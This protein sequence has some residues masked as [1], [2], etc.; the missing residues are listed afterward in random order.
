MGYK[1][2][3][4]IMG[5]LEVGGGALE[6]LRYMGMPVPNES[7]ER[8]EDPT[9]VIV[10][11]SIVHKEEIEV[12]DLSSH[13]I[14][15]LKIDETRPVDALKVSETRAA[16]PIQIG[17]GARIVKAFFRVISRFI[18]CRVRKTHARRLSVRQMSYKQ[19]KAGSQ[20]PEIPEP[21]SIED[22]NNRVCHK[23]M[24]DGRNVDEMRKAVDFMLVNILAYQLPGKD[25]H[26][27]IIK[28]P[29]VHRDLMVEYEVKRTFVHANGLVAYALEPL[30]DK[31]ALPRLLFRGTQISMFVKAGDDNPI[32]GIEEDMEKKIGFRSYDAHKGEISYWLEGLSKKAIVLGHSLGGAFALRTTLDLKNQSKIE[33]CFVYNSP[34]IE[35]ETVEKQPYPPPI[36]FCAIDGDPVSMVGSIPKDCFVY[37]YESKTK[38]TEEKHNERTPMHIT[39]GSL[40]LYCFMNGLAYRQMVLTKHSVTC[41]KT[42]VLS[43]L[44]HNSSKV[45]ECFRRGIYGGL[46]GLE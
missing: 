27:M 34:G 18:A 17:L 28:I 4:V 33:R 10:E 19:L 3:I 15:H 23:Y 20:Q 11:S 8:V 7:V 40:P 2:E 39:K 25:A 12:G 1:E 14:E 35:R 31:E 43:W 42:R 41:F 29:D 16:E 24:R 22:W 21:I 44:L 36:E 38:R 6:S 32:T 46:Q 30:T 13:H 9:I 26:G 37:S 5:D 45:R